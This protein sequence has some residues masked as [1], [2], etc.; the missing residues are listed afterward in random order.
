MH[1]IY[2]LFFSF[3]QSTLHYKRRRKEKLSDLIAIVYQINARPK[4]YYLSQEAR[5]KHNEFDQK[6]IADISSVGFYVNLLTFS[7]Y[8]YYMYVKFIEALL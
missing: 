1:I 6:N 7:Q 4:H 3:I 8:I 5:E 2:T